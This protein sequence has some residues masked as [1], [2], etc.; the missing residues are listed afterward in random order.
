MSIC[1]LCV[2]MHPEMCIFVFFF[3]NLCS[4]FKTFQ[5]YLVKAVTHILGTIILESFDAVFSLYF[6]LIFLNLRSFA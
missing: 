5:L 2:Y 6:Y 1:M 3:T 4:T